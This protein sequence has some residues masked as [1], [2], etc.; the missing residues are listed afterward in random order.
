MS[1]KPQADHDVA[2]TTNQTTMLQNIAIKH[3]MTT[4]TYR[5]AQVPA[6]QANPPLTLNTK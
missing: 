4:P 2:K 5:P 6:H 1:Q 3:P